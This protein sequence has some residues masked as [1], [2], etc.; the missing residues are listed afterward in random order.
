MRMQNV[1]PSRSGSVAS[2]KTRR[3]LGPWSSS[4][5]IWCLCKGLETSVPSETRT[6][7]FI[8][9]LF[10][11]WKHPRCPSEGDCTDKLWAIQTAEYYS[12]LKEMSYQTTKKHGGNLNVYCKQK[13][14]IWKDPILRYFKICHSAKSKPETIKGSVIATGSRWGREDSYGGKYS[15]MVS[16][17]MMLVMCHTL[18]QT[19][20][21]YNTKNE[22]RWTTHIGRLWRVSAGSATVTG[23]SLVAGVNNGGGFYV[24]GRVCT[25]NL[26]NALN[27]VKNLKL[28]LKR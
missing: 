4:H 27:F 26:C 7:V 2:Y 14:P 6:W 13:S 3:A 8:T 17:T 9:T 15:S 16:D 10:V 24:W 19:H 23:R 22:L 5:V 21:M 25:E 28:L 12:V 20:S 11:T 18:V 1:R